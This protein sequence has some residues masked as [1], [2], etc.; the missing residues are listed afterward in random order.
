MKQRLLSLGLIAVYVVAAGMLVSTVSANTLD[1]GRVLTATEQKDIDTYWNSL[2]PDSATVSDADVVLRMATTSVGNIEEVKRIAR[3]EVINAYRVPETAYD[4]N[5]VQLDPGD[6]TIESITAEEPLYVVNQAD[7]HDY[8]YVGLRKG[9]V[10]AYEA[11][12]G[13][14]ADARTGIASLAPIP[15]SVQQANLFKVMPA[16]AKSLQAKIERKTGYRF[17]NAEPRLVKIFILDKIPT[18]D[19]WP[20]YE[21]EKGIY[22]TV[23]GRLFLKDAP[24]R[25]IPKLKQAGVPLYEPKPDWFEG[26]AEAAASSDSVDTR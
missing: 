19:G 22:L 16:E 1:R 21:L 6:P 8:Y 25:W 14:G 4:E 9:D 10:I 24:A 15:E 18:G 23:D 7:G 17:A 3:L 26:E 5:G 20:F 2:G 13:A 11:Y 12:L